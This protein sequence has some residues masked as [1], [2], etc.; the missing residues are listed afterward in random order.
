M[1]EWQIGQLANPLPFGVPTKM[2][3]DCEYYGRSKGKHSRQVPHCSYIASISGVTVFIQV[4]ILTLQYLGAYPIDSAVLRFKSPPPPPSKKTQI[5][6][7][8]S[9][10]N[11]NILSPK[12]LPTSV[13]D[14]PARS[15]RKCKE[16]QCHI[17]GELNH[18][19]TCSCFQRDVEV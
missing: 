1:G 6:P 4:S 10:F 9:S 3:K 16:L 17:F 14:V 19:C 2:G 7:V 15:R 8:F 12:R 13:I 18:V 5:C 11:F